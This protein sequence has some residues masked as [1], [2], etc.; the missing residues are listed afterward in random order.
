LIC[1]TPE[2][3]ENQQA[4]IRALKEALELRADSISQS[5]SFIEAQGSTGKK[6]TQLRSIADI[7]LFVGLRVQDYQDIIRKDAKERDRLVGR[8]LDRFVDDWFLPAVE[9][10]EAE[11]VQKTFSQHP[12]LSLGLMGLDVDI[13]CCFDLSAETIAKDGPITAVDR[14]VHHSSFVAGKLTP[15]KRDDVRLLKSFVRAC[16]AYGD[17]CAVGRMGFT[18]YSL[19]LLVLESD[20]FA[21]AIGRLVQIDAE[22]ID[23]MRRSLVKLRGI[24]SFR[25]DHILIVDPTDHGRNVASSFDER[26]VRWVQLRARQVMEYLESGSMEKHV[27]LLVEDE[28]PEAPIPKAIRNNALSF[29]FES[30]GTT[31]YTVLR[32]K[33]HRLARRISSQWEREDTGEARFGKSL[34]EIY[35]E[36]DRFAIGAIVQKA[37]ISED[38]VRQGPP[39]KMKEAAERFLQTHPEAYEEGGHLWVRVTRKWTDAEALA[40]SVIGQHSI[41]GLA[42]TAEDTAVSKSVLRTLY[43]Y[44]MPVEKDFSVEE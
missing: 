34:T 16:H 11:N 40:K 31:H 1:P 3:I 25:D 38:Y 42:L 36:G 22:P 23:P 43:E 13:L 18:G 6:Q 17:D 19:E 27:D 41:K 44:A 20:S 29:E 26:A 35:F 12:Y 8:V 39:V 32:D 28:I 2:E 4:A 30:D 5:Y 14:T 7:D 10:L 15:E 33:L 9:T 21:D 37:K 24:S